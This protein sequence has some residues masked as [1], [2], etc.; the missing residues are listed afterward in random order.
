MKDKSGSLSARARLVLAASV[1]LALA[2]IVL[3]LFWFGYAFPRHQ[4]SHI[5]QIESKALQI[6]RLFE[7]VVGHEPMTRGRIDAENARLLERAREMAG[8]HKVR[9]FDAAGVII[10]S[11]D[12]DEIGTANDHDYFWQQVARG[13]VLSKLVKTDQKTLEH[14]HSMENVI[15]TYVP[16]MDGSLFIGA[17]EVYLD[18]THDLYTLENVTTDLTVKFLVVASALMGLFIALV[19]HG[20]RV[21]LGKEREQNRRLQD[22][23]DHR[24]HVEAQ[25]RENQ[26]RFDH[27]AHH[28]ALTG[29]ANRRLFTAHLDHALAIA[30]REEHRLAVMFLDLD[31]FKTVNDSLGHEVGDKLLVEVS[32]R[33]LGVVRQTDTLARMGGDEFAILLE[34]VEDDLQVSSLA[35]RLLTVLDPP[36]HIGEFELKAGASIGIAV[37][38]RDGATADE[39]LKNADTAMYRAKD[40]GRGTFEYYMPELNARAQARLLLEGSIAHAIERDELELYFQPQLN[41]ASGTLHGAEALLRWNHGELGTVSPAEFIPIAEESGLIVRIGEWVLHEACRQARGWYDRGHRHF[42]I[43]VN[44]SS[45]QFRDRALLQKVRGALASSRLPPHC[46]ELELTESLLMDHPEESIGLLQEFSDLGISIA[47]DDFGTGYS[48][49]NYLRKFPIHRLKIDRSFVEDIQDPDDARIVN[50]IVNLAHGLDLEV[51]A[52]GIEQQDQLD[53]LRQR[54]CALGQGYF[55]SPPVPA[56]AFQSLWIDGVGANPVRPQTGSPGILPAT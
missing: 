11:T 29:L 41:L 9:L 23:I 31:R 50:T 32:R 48:S 22:E 39:L 52:E 42:T 38:F 27:L 7:T 13:E 44:L 16:V 2:A 46:L 45:R 25:L 54:G 55:F 3:A 36:V 37:A 18:A 6:A 1:A 26:R 14:D 8:L 30:K 17:F 28:D 49:L 40:R 51:I 12:P 35:E 15:E 10:H 20:Y 4:H 21:A 5:D 43:A 34:H 24:R 19:R 53:F 56:D 47:I 33:L